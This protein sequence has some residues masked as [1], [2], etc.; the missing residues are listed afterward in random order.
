MYKNKVIIA[1]VCG[2]EAYLGIKYGTVKRWGGALRPMRIGVS[3]TAKVS[4][5]FSFMTPHKDVFTV[6]QREGGRE[7]P[8][9]IGKVLWSRAHGSH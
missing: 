1:A 4:E 8:P 6:S 3:L 2:L 9:N 5:K 7:N